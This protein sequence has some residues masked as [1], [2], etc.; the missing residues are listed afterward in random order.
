MPCGFEQYDWAVPIDASTADMVQTI[1]AMHATGRGEIYLAKAKAM[2]DAIVNVQCPN[3]LIPTHCMT[4]KHR[5]GAG[6]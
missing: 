3:G 4:P 2:A 1:M 6:F 5:R